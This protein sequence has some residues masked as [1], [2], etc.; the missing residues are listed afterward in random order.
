MSQSRKDTCDILRSAA[1]V[2][3]R[4]LGLERAGFHH[5]ESP[6]VRHNLKA[7]GTNFRLPSTNLV[8]ISVTLVEIRHRHLYSQNSKRYSQEQIDTSE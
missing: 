1:K 7:D 4:Y 8:M 3:S 5:H 6:E 2:H